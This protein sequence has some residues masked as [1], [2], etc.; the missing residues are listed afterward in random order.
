MVLF[1]S[2][3]ELELKLFVNWCSQAEDSNATTWSTPIS[4]KTFAIFSPLGMS[5][6][7]NLILH[8]SLFELESSNKKLSFLRKAINYN[9]VMILKYLF[10]FSVSF[11]FGKFCVMQFTVGYSIIK[12]N[13][14]SSNFILTGYSKK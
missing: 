3:C 5:R 14:W 11:Y 4:E 13:N 10:V 2:F 1:I 12:M 8:F 9:L 6:T 7:T